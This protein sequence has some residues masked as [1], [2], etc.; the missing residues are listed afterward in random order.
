MSLDSAYDSTPAAGAAFSNP[1]PHYVERYGLSA[2]P[3]SG[4]HEDR[5]V[6]LDAERLQRL[7]MLEHLTRYSELLLI[8][9]GPKGIGKTSLLQRFRLNADED[10]LVSQV[11][12]NPM[13]DADTL[14]QAIA[15]GFGLH[16]PND[17]PVAL[18]DTLYRHLAALHHQGKIPL[19]LIDDAHVLPQDG[20]EALF[21]LADAEASDGN[22]LRIILFSDPQIETMLQSPAIQSLRERIT[23]SMSIP[24][25][26]EEQTVGYIRHRL[27]VAGLQDAL[28]FSNK[29]LHKIFHNSGGIPAR[30][31]ECAHLIL[32]G[33]KLDQAVKDFHTPRLN[34][35]PNLKFLTLKLPAGL[36]RFK[37]WQVA[38]TVT[39]V[40]LVG[41][42]L[43]Y[44][45]DINALFRSGQ[46]Q[47]K[48]VT[49]P[50]PVAKKSAPPVASPPAPEPSSPKMPAQET[51]AQRTLTTKPEQN[52]AQAKTDNKTVAP[53]VATEKK[54]TP[55]AGIPA[56][57]PPA[58]VAAKEA[59]K[60]TVIAKPDSEPEPPQ[61]PAPALPATSII[62]S[63]ISPN[64][65][66]SSRK[67]QTI[68][69]LGKHFSKDMNVTV[70]WSGGHKILSG[71][72]INII[73]PTEMELHITVGRNPDTWKVRLQDPL[74]KQKVEARFKVMGATALKTRQP[75]THLQ[76]GFNG[77]NWIT[78]QNPKHFTLQLLSSQHKNSLLAFAKRHGLRE[79][80]AW[81][82]RLH[83]RHPWYALIQGRYPDRAQAKRAANMMIKN[84][85]TLKPWIRPFADIQKII[86]QE[87][88]TPPPAAIDT[89]SRPPSSPN[90][91]TSNAAWLWSQDPS[92]YTLQL[93]GGRTEAGILHFIRQHKLAG[94]AVYYRTLRN[95]RPWYILVY[96][97]YPDH[98]RAK[99]AIA[100]LPG[101]LH[102]TRPW[103]RS[104]ASIQA[105]LQ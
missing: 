37:F 95:K 89:P 83:N 10:T 54:T 38:G 73:S 51:S 82:A 80:L 18:Q 5:F 78:K 52:P 75:A 72:Q 6:Y 21:N 70:F 13:M 33:D 4:R 53:A 104:F 15:T 76:R 35:S 88:V 36:A 47:Q 99:A 96:N 20:L 61:V 34:F 28:P 50:L 58:P 90:D 56:P 32:N 84:I 7:N 46:Q 25:L 55:V 30:I 86:H 42:V 81:F 14:L 65:V 23:H 40:I 49:I 31:N 67:P 43:A 24:A 59:K 63:D 17:D 93:L 3:F 19:L 92:H 94:K 11:D 45:D 48:T 22:L 27:Q 64:P 68:A 79:D 69:I 44:Q 29:D 85:P 26:N 71:S 41:L 66:N 77:K 98:A 102:K 2:A 16:K 8:I 103:P 101:S 100:N 60:Q 87:A 74:S 91:K 12:A 1:V 39:A 105:E 9:S 62:I 57:V 97:N